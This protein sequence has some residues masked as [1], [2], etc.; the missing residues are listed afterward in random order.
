MTILTVVTIF[1][2]IWLAM[3]LITRECKSVFDVES[4]ESESRKG[5]QD[6]SRITGVST[7]KKGD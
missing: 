3:A 4:L 7:I 5:K 6:P 2:I 1:I